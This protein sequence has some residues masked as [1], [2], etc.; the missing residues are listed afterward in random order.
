MNLYYG[1]AVIALDGAA[2]TG[3]F[4]ADRLADPR[5]LDF[6][7]RITAHVDPE[8]EAMGAPFRHASRMRVVTRDGRAFEKLSL[9]RRGSPENPLS[10]EEVANKFRNVVAPCMRPADA[11]R[12][13]ALVGRFET[14]ANVGE[15]MRLAG[16]AVNA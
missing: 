2:F 5:I 8:I 6:I 3:Q 1:L 16:T 11:T 13:E 10:A 12:I 7:T 4:R 14:L 9:H 15:F